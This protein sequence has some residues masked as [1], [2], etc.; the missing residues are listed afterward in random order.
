MYDPH[1]FGYGSLVNRRTHIYNPVRPATLFGWRREWR[2]T[3]LRPAAFLTARPVEGDA[4]IDGLIAPVPGADWAALDLR[5]EGYNRLPTTAVRHDMDHE[6]E[7]AVYSIPPREDDGTDNP[8]LLSYLDVVVQGFLEVFG[9]DGVTRFF[10][11]TDNW[12]LPI[13][14]D[15]HMPLYPR[16]QEMTLQEVSLT[17][18][19]LAALNVT[20]IPVEETGLGYDA[21]P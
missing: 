17:D 19:W 10:E 12:T 1:F 13:A 16:A 3:A 15:R 6:P 11:S 21:A 7:I 20:R 2:A 18:H 4:Q 5:E 9:E 14:D 8:I